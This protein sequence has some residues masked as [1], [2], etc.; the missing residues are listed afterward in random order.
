MT[1]AIVGLDDPYSIF[2]CTAFLT[3]ATLLCRSIGVPGCCIQ[4]SSE[5]N[6]TH[7]THDD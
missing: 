6:S 5:F 3:E 2:G 1:L 7:S 4:A